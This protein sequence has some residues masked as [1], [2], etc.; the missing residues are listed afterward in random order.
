M[1]YYNYQ[2]KLTK[3]ID[4]SEM[5]IIPASL[6]VYRALEISQHDI[7]IHTYQFKEDLM[8]IMAYAVATG[9]N[10]TLRIDSIK[11]TI[12]IQ[13]YDDM[14]PSVYRLCNK[15]KY[16]DY[17]RATIK[18]Y[19]TEM[20]RV[21]SEIQYL[22]DKNCNSKTFILTDEVENFIRTYAPAYG[23]PMPKFHET[24]SSSDSHTP[25]KWNKAYNEIMDKN[26]NPEKALAKWDDKE[27]QS[28]RATPLYEIE[29]IFQSLMFYVRND[30]PFNDNYTKC[31]RCGKPMRKNSY[32]ITDFVEYEVCMDCDPNPCR[33][34]NSYVS[35]N[36][37]YMDDTDDC[38]HKIT[39]EK[40]LF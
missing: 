30:I 12:N 38:G 40:N 27:A 10:V 23:I 9:K 3:G 4:T 28:R 5:K 2:P 20:M 13:K 16:Y 25:K 32:G 18:P 35:F 33:G 26:S 36:E 8:N 7:Y 34:D 22:R 17:L 31:P 24:Q 14:K 1:L 6:S 37:T 19:T 21:D 39:T 11:E 15:Q 29:R